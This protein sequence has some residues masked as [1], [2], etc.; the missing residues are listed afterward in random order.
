MAFNNLKLDLNS[1]KPG[2]APLGAV[3]IALIKIS[4]RIK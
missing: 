2:F 1:F 3:Q 4:V